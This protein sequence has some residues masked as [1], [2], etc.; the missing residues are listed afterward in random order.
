MV[1]LVNKASCNRLLIAYFK[2]RMV[3]VKEMTILKSKEFTWKIVILIFA[4]TPNIEF[5]ELFDNVQHIF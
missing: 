3:N 4:S 1:P 2:Y 5:E